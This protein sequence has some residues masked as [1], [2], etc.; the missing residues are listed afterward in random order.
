MKAVR[1]GTRGVTRS[2]V[3]MTAGCALLTVNDA[4]MKAVAGSYP[5]GE[6]IFFRGLFVMIPI[7]L[8]A[9]RGG[10][11]HALRATNIRG[12]VLRGLCL[13]ASTFLLITSLRYLPLADAIALTFAGPLILTAVAP[14]ALG[15]RVGWRRRGAVA[16]GFAGVLI[17]LAPGPDGLRW[18][19]LLPLGVAVLEA[20]RD[21]VTRRLVA[22]ESTLSMTAYSSGVVTL[23]ALATAGYGWTPLDAGDAGLLAMAAFCMGAALLLTTEAF[24]HAEVTVVAPFRYSS[25]VWAMLFGIIAFGDWPG[26]T[27]LTGAALVVGSG[28]YI[29]HREARR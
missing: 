4:I 29:L 22:T 25:V 6:S 26:P 20:V 3:L 11:L 16:T 18:A 1:S 19:A 28:L 14:W 9:W 23:C 12:Q 13:A 15:E 27:M 10:G 24:R 7:A 2:V 21:I 5:P 17:M 8:L